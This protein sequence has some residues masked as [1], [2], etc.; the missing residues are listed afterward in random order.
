MWLSYL[1]GTLLLIT[2][3]IL[4][5]IIL[6]QRGRGGGLAGAFGGLGGQSAFGTRA[7]DVFTKITVGITVVWVILAGVTGY[8]MRYEAQGRFVS[9]SSVEQEATVTTPTEGSE[10]AAPKD[11]ATEPAAETKTDAA[12]DS[13]AAPKSEAAPD[14]TATPQSTETPATE[15]PASTTPPE[16]AA[17]TRPESDAAQKKDAP[18]SPQ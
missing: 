16:G 13:S 2:G 8:A 17:T 11:E 1:T 9:G 7:G 18:A 14:S 4:I 15:T 5:L 12:P 10:K 3:L 6:L